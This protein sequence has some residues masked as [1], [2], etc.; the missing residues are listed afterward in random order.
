MNVKFDFNEKNFVVVGASSGI[1]R[2]VAIELA[3]S[4]AKVLAVGR[5]LERLESLKQTAPQKIFTVS[6]DVINANQ[7]DCRYRRLDAVKFF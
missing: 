2:Q 7:D 1:G 4:G 3:E 6:L 5:N